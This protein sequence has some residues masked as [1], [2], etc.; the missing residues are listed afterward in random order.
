MTFSVNSAVFGNTFM[1]PRSV[2]ENH[3]KLASDMQLRV[4]LYI[5]AN[6]GNLPDAETLSE[7]LALPSE[8]V[9][10]ALLYWETAGIIN[11]DGSKDTAPKADK[12]T[13]RVRAGIVKPTREEV[14]RRGFEN[15]KIQLLL[16]EAQ[17]KFGRMLKNNESATLVWL[18]DD[19]GMDV[20]LILMLIEYAVSENK[21][22]VSFIERTAIDWLNNGVQD[23]A[24][25]ERYITA[26][27]AKKTAWKV[28]EAAF[29]IDDRM[30]SAKELEYA[31]R[32][33]NE[34]GFD[35]KMLR[36]AYE[37]CVDAKSKFIMSYTAK[38]I[39]GWKTSGFET[40]EDVLAA[41]NKADGN[42]DFSTHDIDLIEKM[43]NKGYG[44]N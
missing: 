27:Y 36:L 22:N 25:A 17:I 31:D 10:E 20:S 39:E 33:I 9:E 28:V 23:I 21:C 7:A 32:W 43:I 40:V 38:I 26:M 5:F 37:K 34:W 14:A 19:E 24:S 11:I 41:E 35:R 8:A 30:A 1:L 3:L 42:S 15:E 6:I 16:R 18:F 4:I 13:K 2:A 12:P 29:G 44:E